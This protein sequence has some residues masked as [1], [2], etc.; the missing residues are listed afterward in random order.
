MSL[1]RIYISNLIKISNLN[2]FKDK[3]YIANIK[4]MFFSYDVF[5]S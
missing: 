5:F 3:I 1:L 4:F 2:F